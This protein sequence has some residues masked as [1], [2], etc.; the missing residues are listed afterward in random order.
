MGWLRRV[1]PWVFGLFLLIVPV[2]ICHAKTVTL[3]WDPSPTPTVTGYRV[4]ISLNAEMS[5]TLA[6]RDVGDVL[7]TSIADL[8]DH[9]DHW[10]CVKAY[11]GQG[12]ESVCSNIV[13]SPPVAVP[14]KIQSFRFELR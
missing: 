3:S 14:G 8:D 12:H 10:F 7:T 4:L 6:S 11:D 2:G 1:L 5:S 9:V 13:T